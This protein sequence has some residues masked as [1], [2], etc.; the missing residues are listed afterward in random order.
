EI[1][2]LRWHPG[3]PI[4][5]QLT[6]GFGWG[7][8]Q[9]YV[10][11]GFINRRAQII[12]GPGWLSIFMVAAIFGGLHLPNPWLTFVTLAGG[13]IWAAVYQMAPNLFALALSHCLLTWVIVSSLPTSALNYLCIG[14]QYFVLPLA[15]FC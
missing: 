8:V 3:R 5:G 2:F 9:Q 13:T 11:Q 15:V 12:W 6:L 10:L 7:L 1:N 4:F 14:L